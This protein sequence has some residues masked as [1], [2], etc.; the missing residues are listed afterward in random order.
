MRYTYFGTR[1]QELD[2][3]V[4]MPA[5]HTPKPGHW[6][7]APGAKPK[8]KPRKHAGAMWRSN[9]DPDHADLARGTGM[10]VRDRIRMA[11]ACGIIAPDD[12]PTW[13]QPVTHNPYA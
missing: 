3:A 4:P 2:V 9:V 8:V 5:R 11:V 10:S 12:A 13:A 7:I 1:G 6:R